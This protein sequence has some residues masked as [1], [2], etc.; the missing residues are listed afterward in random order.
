M[1]DQ[2]SELVKKGRL[3]PAAD[4]ER[5]INGLLESLNESASAALDPAWEDEIAKR[6][7]EYDT[8]QS[9]PFTQTSSS[10]KPESS[11]PDEASV[12]ARSRA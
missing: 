5:V 6:L 8:A 10:R 7:A 1:Q 2:V 3:L 12:S 4:R 11:L 9:W